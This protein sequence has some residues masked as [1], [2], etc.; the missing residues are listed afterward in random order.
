MTTRDWFATTG[1]DRDPPEID[2]SI[3]HAARVYDYLVGGSTNFAADR[4]AAE[5]A[6][7][8]FPGGVDGAR[9]NARANRAFLRD[10][11]SYLAAQAGIRQFLDI[12]TGIPTE[13]NVHQVAQQVAPESRIVY[14]DH[15]PIVLA[16]AHT[17]LKGTPEGVTAYVDSDLRDPERIVHEAADTLDFTKPVALVLVSILHMIGDG[18][19]PYGI[20]SQLLDSAPAGSYLVLAHMASDIEPEAMAELTRRLEADPMEVVPALRGHAEVSRFF[21]GLELVEPGVVHIDSWRRNDTGTEPGT[22]PPGEMVTPFYC[23]VGRKT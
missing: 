16:H 12:G 9:A 1:P 10:A 11:V 7:A 13:G 22:T 23:A 5:H 3:A 8:A 17:L 20:V 19:D 2:T 15:D 6:F 4:Q 18:D 14:V 21:D